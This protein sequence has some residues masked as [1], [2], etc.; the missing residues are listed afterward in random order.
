MLLLCPALLLLATVRCELALLALYF[1]LGSLAFPVHVLLGLASREV[2]DPLA[3]S[4]AGGLVKFV[5]QMGASSA[6]YPLGVL[7]QTHGWQAVL[8]LLSAVAGG[9]G[10]LA[11]TLWCTVARVAEPAW[12]PSRVSQPHKLKGG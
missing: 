7:Q 12:R 2:V 4:T 1:A 8:C 3:S 6:G 5:A 9:G 10:L 11:A